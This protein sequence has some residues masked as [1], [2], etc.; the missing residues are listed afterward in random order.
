MNQI[1]KSL[2]KRWKLILNI[3]TVIALIITLY[4]VRKDLMATYQNLFHVYAWVLLLIVPLEV[5]NY[6]AQ[7]KLY[8]HLF[9]VVGNKLSYKYLY[10]AAL[11]LNF[12]NHVFPSGGAAGISYFGLRLKNDDISGGKATLIQ[13]MKLGLT[14]FSFEVLILLSV[15]F[16]AI[17]GHVNSFTMLAAG[18]LSTLLLGG[19]IL[20]VYII[21]SKA[22]INSFFGFVT[23]KLN[24]IARI[25][26]ASNRDLI[27]IANARRVF[28]D[29]HNTFQ[30]IRDRIKQ[31]R[32]PFIYALL[33]NI[34]EIAVVYI[35]FIAFGKLVNVGAVILAY[36]VANFAG[37]IS[38]L[39]GGVGIYEALMTAVFLATG[40][41][42]QIS[43]PVII[44][45]RVLNTI[46]Q[47]P[48][49]YY[50]YQ[51]NINKHKSQ[52]A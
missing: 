28:D 38:I 6:H 37:L 45:Y 5:I 50:L 9:R 35:V 42:P 26:R 41:P 8:Q 7:A 39:P 31:L 14:F 13:I 11:E 46:L 43:L 18:A 36:G 25:F 17:G 49:G 29:F 15:V 33:A 19:S 52:L 2:I 3:V 40:I 23:V 51:R 24:Q 1:A 4:A 21:G 12:V 10:L 32:A 34:T 47:I 20:F 30:E 48:P 44:M 27:N 22:R 16:L